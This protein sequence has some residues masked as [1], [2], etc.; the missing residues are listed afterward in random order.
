MNLLRQI[1]ADNNNNN[2]NNNG[3]MS[4]GN[5]H[6]NVN[7]FSTV[8]TTTDVVVHQEKYGDKSIVMDFVWV[9]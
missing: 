6:K 9:L 8:K 4:Y 3:W 5:S 7:G 1:K 2:N